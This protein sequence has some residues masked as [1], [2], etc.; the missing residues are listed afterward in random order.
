M[1]IQPFKLERYFA[2]YEFSTPYLLCCSDCEALSMK[3]L[4]SMSDENSLKMWGDLKLDYTESQGHHILREEVSKL[5]TRIKPENVMIL[6]PEEGIYI[7]MNSILSKGDHV[8]ATFPGYQSLYEIANSLDCE[9]SKWTP[10]EENAWIFDVN[11]LQNL[12]KDN[13]KL[14]VINFPHNPTGATLQQ[15]DLEKIIEITK[16]KNIILFSDE[17]YRFLEHDKA[18]R[19]SSACD[20]YDNA[21]SLFGMSK[22]FALAGLRI[23]WLAT[24]NNGILAQ[25]A[26]YKDYTTICSSGPSEILSI[27]ALRAKDEI[28]KRN[29]GIIKDN[30]KVLDEFFIDYAKLFDWYKP[31]AGPLGFP[32]LKSEKNVA[33]FCLDLVE[34]KGVLLL[35]ANQ[36][37]YESNNFRLSFARKNMP[38]ALIKFKEYI[39]ENY[40]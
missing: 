14:I 7:A 6:T 24:Q 25:V 21:I 5:Y 2:K 10:K 22:S 9:V 37:D 12:I 17:M 3:E 19:T 33:D 4:L 13:T 29:L 30:L 1:K 38:K 26:T 16:Q 31:K 28:L 11:D 18:N 34:K 32:K 36:Y 15:T 23:G 35:P 40:Q 8:I 20:L 39:D 27:M